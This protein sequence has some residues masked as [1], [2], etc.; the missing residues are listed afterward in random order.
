M[1]QACKLCMSAYPPM[2][3]PAIQDMWCPLLPQ[4][5]AEYLVVACLKYT[6]CAA[7]CPGAVHVPA[8][9]HTGPSLK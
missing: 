8:P 3:L 5:T 6:V 1:S 7:F 2:D 4:R 9:E